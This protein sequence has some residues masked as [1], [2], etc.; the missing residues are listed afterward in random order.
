MAEVKEMVEVEVGPEVSSHVAQILQASPFLRTIPGLECRITVGRRTWPLVIY[1]GAAAAA[2]DLSGQRLAQQ[3]PGDGGRAVALVVATRLS[4]RDRD[5]LE[6]AGH[7]YV[8][9]VGALHV[10]TPT[11]LVHVEPNG[12]TQRGFIPAPRGLGVVAVR[13]VQ[14]LLHI[15][16][17]QWK[18]SDLATET[19][20]SLGQAHNV[21]M[22]LDAEGLL[23]QQRSGRAV[24]RRLSDPGAVLDW[25][26][27]VPAASKLHERLKTY[28]Y[29][30]NPD[31]L[32]LRLAEAAHAS[33]TQWALT[34]AGAA[35]PWNAGSVVT[36]LP[37]L[38]I[39]IDP[40]VPLIAVAPRL[41]LEA[42]DAGHNVLLVRDV[43]QLATHPPVPVHGPLAIAP[44]VRVYLDMLTEPRGRDAATLFREAVLGY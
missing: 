11:V 6:Q 5:R 16:E 22:R 19:G 14:H 36:A 42:V 37:V 33:K 39:R 13:I 38:M 15:P 44:K 1:R 23:Q 41:G 27:Q 2:Q 31:A 32:V 29:A 20:A 4:T 17:R 40:Q 25:L 8:D 24:L 34:G 10:Q 21:L 26:A 28:A 12:S 9:A 30:P 43:G 18:V 7:S 3:R 35:K